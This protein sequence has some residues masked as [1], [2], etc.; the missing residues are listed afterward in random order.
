MNAADAHI[1]AAPNVG[2]ASPPSPP[3]PNGIFASV[4]GGDH[5][6]RCRWRSECVEMAR[7]VGVTFTLSASGCVVLS[8][9]RFHEAA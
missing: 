6:V 4:T 8:G 2:V 9:L 3:A 1:R 7:I 5:H